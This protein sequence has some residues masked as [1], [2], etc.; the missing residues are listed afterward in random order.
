MA[1]NN[2]ANF[3]ALTMGQGATV[4]G[5]L[6]ALG[7]LALGQVRAAPPAA[8]AAPTARF[9][10]IEKPVERAEP[11]ADIKRPEDVQ[12]EQ[13][14]LISQAR[15]ERTRKQKLLPEGIITG[16]QIY[17]LNSANF[18]QQHGYV[19][20]HK[21]LLGTQDAKN[22]SIIA[23]A[24]T[25]NSAQLGPIDPNSICVKCGLIN[26]PGHNG[27]IPFPGVVPH[28]LFHPF[29]PM[30][31]SCVCQSCGN[32]LIDPNT[33]R[34]REFHLVPRTK[35]LKFLAEHSKS[36]KC[37]ANPLA[38]NPNGQ[39]MIS[40]Q[41]NPELD[42]SKLK[43]Q[44][45]IMKIVRTGLK[46]TEKVSVIFPMNEIYNICDKISDD[47][48]HRMGF[49]KG[50]P[51]NLFSFGQIAPPR[52]IR[53][54]IYQGGKTFHDSITHLLKTIATHAFAKGVDLSV[55][56][57]D[58]KALYIEAPSKKNGGAKQVMAIAPRIQGH[59]AVLRQS[60][61]GKRNDKSARGVATGAPGNKLNQLDVPLKWM[62]NITKPVKVTDLNYDSV[63]EMI[64]ERKIK[65]IKDKNCTVRDFNYERPPPVNVGDTLYRY[66]QDGDWVLCNR[67]PTLHKTSCMSYQ[68]RGVNFDT[69]GAPLSVTTPY[70]LDFDGD[71]LNIWVI[72]ESKTEAEMEFIT[73]TKENIMSSEN[74]RPMMGCVMNTIT[75]SYILTGYG[76]G[77]ALD[78]ILYDE[79]YNTL[80]SPPSREDLLRRLKRYN[81][82]QFSGYG[83][84]SLLFPEGFYYDNKGVKI[85]DGVMISGRIKKSHI[86]T[87]S[88]SIVQDIHKKFGADGSFNFLNNAP[89][90]VG[91]WILEKGFSV[92]ITDFFSLATDEKGKLYNKNEKFLQEELSKINLQ[93]DT[94][95]EKYTDP[96]AE[97]ARQQRISGILNNSRTIGLKLA[98]EIL[99]SENQ[100]AIM[101]EKGAG[102]KGAAANIAQTMGA[103]GQ[104]NVHGS[105][106]E[107]TLSGKTRT[108][109][110]FYIGDKRPETRGF[111][112]S[113]FFTGLTPT[114]L[115]QLQQGGREGI[116]DTA[117]KTSQTGEMQ[118]S[119]TKSFENI[120][121]GN[122]GSVRNTS[123]ALFSTVYGGCGYA[124]SEQLS[125]DKS[126]KTEKT[127]FIDLQDLAA[128][129]N[130][131]YGF[132]PASL[133][134]QLVAERKTPH[135]EKFIEPPPV[136]LREINP[137]PITKFE[138]SRIIGSR[139]MQLA[140]NAPPIIDVGTET[141]PFKIAKEEYKTGQLKICVLRRYVNQTIKIFPTLE[142]IEN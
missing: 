98:D 15:E 100:M 78:E 141:D 13:R 113:S 25:V 74:N 101:T 80:P 42:V 6:P 94:L 59:D 97:R 46:K 38:N 16:S 28:P 139:A 136:Q 115:F 77:E 20:I 91:K 32:M 133:N 62:R 14:Y 52:S 54:P 84:Y 90:L 126:G 124:V 134:N 70:N 105:A 9:K 50:H 17:A 27:V 58:M 112:K 51:R 88:R 122:D 128:E 53:P 103:V 12:K 31:L 61:Q 4:A 121:V 24:G 35:R 45:I 34:D 5:Q 67:Q 108:L 104:Q 18:D 65:K 19:R 131:E 87:S 96:I 81:I 93:L 40:C 49:R 116:L 10:R 82:P 127:S 140:N 110:V 36:I 107:E 75:G 102:T 3:R 48:A 56:Y 1:E 73:S 29:I 23:D 132:V 106:I 30:I 79:I 123:G 7:N 135:R 39:H 117:L 57:E 125:I 118:R 55:I 71:D 85:V 111:I 137:R 76:R 44:G 21:P 99:S 22:P 43:D 8:R 26:C 114:E 41:P 129:I 72:Q 89:V 142:N 95:G 33:Y 130:G 60:I 69:V 83:V 119:M 68:I 11:V 120:I 63:M 47:D 2:Q 109:P 64:R 92:S 86:G 37:M 66:L 138:K